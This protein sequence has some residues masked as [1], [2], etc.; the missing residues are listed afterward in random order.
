[1]IPPTPDVISRSLPDGWIAYRKTVQLIPN[2]PSPSAYGCQVWVQRTDGSEARDLTPEGANCATMPALSPD[3]QW[4]AFLVGYIRHLSAGLGGT[5]WVMRIDGSE[6]VQLRGAPNTPTMIVWSWDGRRIANYYYGDFKWHVYDVAG[7]GT[8]IGAVDAL[9]PD[10]WRVPNLSPDG[11]YRATPCE[12]LRHGYRQ[13]CITELASDP[14]PLGQL[15]LDA[16][17]VWS[18]DGQW[19]AYQDKDGTYAVHPDGSG[20]ER[21]TEMAGDWF[22]DPA[23]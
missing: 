20:R 11:L 19:I 5:L 17:I 1:V 10:L 13:I 18:P 3:G 15:H 7:G 23:D 21:I 12:E 14:R 6:A 2:D 16:G 9:E 22:F 4:V 8:A